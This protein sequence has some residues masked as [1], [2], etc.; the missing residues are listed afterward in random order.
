[1]SKVLAAY[2]PAGGTTGKVAKNLAA[3]EGADLLEIRPETHIRFRS[4]PFRRAVG[5]FR[6]AG[7]EGASQCFF[8]TIFGRYLPTLCGSLRPTQTRILPKRKYP[9][10]HVTAIPGDFLRPL[11]HH[12]QDIDLVSQKGL[13]AVFI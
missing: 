13:G 9:D 6:S 1:M 4:V 10:S 2:Y 12:K 3:A 11:L 5:T 8:Q 7:C